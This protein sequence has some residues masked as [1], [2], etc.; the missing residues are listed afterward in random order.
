M[1]D[2]THDIFRETV[3]R[4]LDQYVEPRYQE[5]EDNQE[6]PRDF[7]LK[8]GEAGLLCPGVPE[9]YGGAGAD[10]LFNAIVN[11]EI[12]RHGFAG[13]SGISVHSDVVVPYLVKFGSEDQK[14]DWLPK[15]VSGEVVTS[16]GMT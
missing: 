11:E 15:M 1:Y 6:I 8:A 16:I 3:R 4:F 14:R 12:T 13:L 7:W 2:E 10:Y 5:W 9:E